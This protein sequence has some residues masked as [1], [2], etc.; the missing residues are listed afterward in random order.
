MAL[1]KSG[2]DKAIIY[3]TVVSVAVLCVQTLIGVSWFQTYFAN[4]RSA[5][6]PRHIL[7]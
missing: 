7:P 1:T 2:T 4:I 3:L 6:I 5:L